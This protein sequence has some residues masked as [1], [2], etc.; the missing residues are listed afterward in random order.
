M[1]GRAEEAMDGGTGPARR[2]RLTGEERRRQIIEAAA[3]L[4]SRKGFR[5]TTTR[6]IAEAVGVSEAMLFKHFVTK[7]ELY[8]AIIETKSHARRVMD[9]A[10]AAAERE[11]DAEVLRTL[12]REMIG[13]TRTDPTLMRLTFFSA[14][15]GHALS[16]IMFRSR[17]QQLDDFLSG[18]FAKRV[19]AGAF[20]PVDPLQAA[21]NFI[22]MVAYH[23][24]RFE[25]FKQ[26]PPEHLTTER[27]IEEMV[28]LFLNG[29]RRA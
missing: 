3:T 4:F 2:V 8:A 15:E 7:E 16:D 24:Q 11:D 18:Y 14:L 17:V 28:Q 25:L 6:E 26:K 21:W 10:L 1:A 23:V 20:R 29:V 12:A 13:R 5:G 22:G 27:A 9:P 19:A